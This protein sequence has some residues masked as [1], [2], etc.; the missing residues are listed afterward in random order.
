[1]AGGGRGGG[2]APAD[3][4]LH[5]PADGGHAAAGAVRDEL[6]LPGRRGFPRWILPVDGLATASGPEQGP[7]PEDILL[8]PVVSRRALCGHGLGS[9]DSRL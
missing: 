9:F 4:P 2:D 5:D 8:F 1:A 6:A 3:L 7:G